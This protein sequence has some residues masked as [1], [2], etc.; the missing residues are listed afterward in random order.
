[1]PH[2]AETERLGDGERPVPKFRLRR[3]HLDADATF[4]KLPQG[5][6]GLQ[7]RDAPTGDQYPRRHLNHLLQAA[8][9]TI[10]LDGRIQPP[11]TSRSASGVHEVRRMINP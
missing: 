5:Q 11:Q 1:V 2:L 8:S 9:A 6:R 10:T 3:Q 4:P 7:S